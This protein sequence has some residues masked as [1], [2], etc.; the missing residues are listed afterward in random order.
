MEEEINFPR[1]GTNRSRASTET[2]DKSAKTSTSSDE[3]KQS[4]K[5]SNSGDFLFGKDEIMSNKK[6][7]RKKKRTSD[8][9]SS[10]AFSSS[11]KL[12]IGGA[13]V[14]QPSSS[15]GIKKPALI[16]A[17]SF[18]KLAKGTKILGLVREV[19]PAY[20]VVSLP[21]ML[22]GFI[23][24]S[25]VAMDKILSVGMMLP[26]VV[27]KVASETVAVPQANMSKNGKKKTEVKR[28]IELSI[29]PAMLN[30]GL[31]RDMIYDGMTIRGRIQS[32]E[33]HGCIVDLGINGLKSTS[34]F[35]KFENIEGSYDVVDVSEEEDDSDEEEEDEK[36]DT[37]KES[38]M[39]LL[40][41]GRIYDFTI[42]SVPSKVENGG[43]SSLV[44]SIIQLKLETPSTRSKNI[45]DNTTSKRQTIRTL[46]PGMLLNVTVEHFA[47]NGL[48]VSF[49]GHVF[50][51]SIDSS[52]LGAQVSDDMKKRGDI[53]ASKPVEQLWW[54]SVFVGDLRTVKAR[55]IVVD[56]VTKIIRLSLL[57]HILQLKIPSMNDFPPVGSIVDNAKVVRLDPGIGALLA[58]PSDEKMNE[59]TENNENISPTSSLENNKLY[60]LGS[61]IQCAYV[62]ISKAI[63]DGKNRTPESVFGKKFSPNTIIPKLRVLSTSYW[64]DNVVSCATS[65]SIVSSAVLTH[66]DLRPGD[67]YKSVPIIATLKGG[68]VF[69][70]LGAMGNIKGLVPSMH[71]F[72]RGGSESSAFRSK[73]RLEKFKVGNKIDVRC[74]FVDAEEKKCLL[75]TKK[76]LL[77]S[78]ID[79]PIRDYTQIEKGRIGTGFVTRVSKQG[80]VVTFYNNVYGRISARKLAE[81]LGVE[82][83]TVDYQIGDVVKARVVNC[84]QRSRP[85]ED[86]GSSMHYILS[87][88]LDIT[89]SDDNDMSTDSQGISGIAPGVVLPPKCMKVVEFVTSKVGDSNDVVPGYA[90]VTIKTKYLKDVIEGE[91]KDSIDCKIPFEQLKDSYEE[92]VSESPDAIDSEAKKVLKVGKKIDKESIILA[93]TRRGIYIVSLKP[94]LVDIAKASNDSASDKSD[95]LLPGPSSSLL[96]GAYLKGYCARIDHRHGAFIRFLD[97]LT[98]LVPKSKGGLDIKP[99]DTINCKVISLDTTNA[100][101]PRILLKTVSTSH[102]MYNSVAIMPNKEGPFARELIYKLINDGDVIGDVKVNALTFNQATVTILNKKFDSCKDIKA[103]IHMTLADPV[104]GKLST[105]PLSKVEDE[106]FIEATD[107][108]LTITK[109]HPFSQWKVGSIIQ[110][111]VFAGVSVRDGATYIELTNR[112]SDTLSAKENE[113]LAPLIADEARLL[114][115]GM[116]VSGII[117]ALHSKGIWVQ[118]N[119]T[120]SGFISGLDL[121]SN[122]AMLNNMNNYYK[123][124]GRIKCTVKKDKGESSGKERLRLS[125]SELS[126][127][128][129]ESSTLDETQQLPKE[130][131]VLVGRVNRKMKE[132]TAPS[133]MFDLPGGLVGRCDITELADMDE[134]SNMP[135]GRYEHKVKKSVENKKKQV[136]KTEPTTAE[137]Q[138][139][140]NDQE[141]DNEDDLRNEQ[142]LMGDYPNGLY[143]RCVVLTKP[144]S[145]KCS[146][147]INVSLRESRMKGAL[148]EG[149][150]PK[151][152]SIV[153]A[154]VIQTTKKG[155]FFR[156]SRTVE[157][158]AILKELSDGFL[159]DP[160]SLFP[161]GRLVVAKVKSVRNI[162][163]GNKKTK[164]AID[165]D[166]RESI[167]LNDNK[168]DFDDVKEGEKYRGV[169]TRIES[170]GVFVR[171]DNSNVS[172]L[173]HLS[174]CS[175]DYVKD[176]SSLYNPGDLVKVLVVRVEK[177]ER[178]IGMS[179]R[180][181]HF[182]EDDESIGESSS[183]SDDDVE[184]K[185]AG[186]D[187][188]D[189]IDSDDENFVSKLATKIQGTENENKD[190]VSSANSWDSDSS[191][192]DD[193]S[194]ESSTSSNEGN[195]VETMDTDVGFDWGGN[196][197]P[198]NEDPSK[199]NSD[200]SSSDSSDSEDDNDEKKSSHKSRKKAAAKKDKEKEIAQMEQRI[201]DGMADE[202]P[203]TEA[204]FERL[205]ASDPNSSENW[206]RYMSFYLSLANI[207]SARKVANRALERIEFRREEDKLNVFLAL[208]TL[209]H[210]YGSNETFDTTINKASQYNNPKQVYLR[211]CEML[212]KDAEKSKNAATITRTDEMFTKM[213]KKFKSKKTVWV[214]CFR[215]F[216]KNGRY[217]KAHELRKRSL[218][219][220]AP[221]KHVEVM[222]RYAQLEYEYGDTERARTIY[223]GLLDKNTKRLDLLFVYVDKE[224]KHGT[225]DIARRI[226]QRVVKPSEGQTPFKFSDKQMKSLFKKW[227]RMED[228]HG[229]EESQQNVKSAAKEYI[230]QSLSTK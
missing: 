79:D 17:V 26:V 102:M 127:G 103:R 183:D 36:M 69:V 151:E 216:L 83:P 164:T 44:N 167:L 22:T 23:R 21:T 213:C 206:I 91:Q 124:G 210:R 191:D 173:V 153:Q 132:V 8:D 207:D 219:S 88:S 215:Y 141:D 85:V 223:D 40:N 161:P 76:S 81:E 218:M 20:A 53:L 158:R 222:S 78:D 146:S 137:N 87:L 35:L 4:R 58:L 123:V 144:T 37:D 18:Q 105:M 188:D 192:D 131:D 169:V 224:V 122:V 80:I 56:P 220:L 138:M 51:G 15:K 225:I 172:G 93:T 62:H 142:S 54:K 175:D 60:A 194:D 104:V 61:T 152:K 184:M 136:S 97:N 59:D 185:D 208:I 221:H 198:A 212:E 176:L 74:L 28:R 95:I 82:D 29:A 64:M 121:G 174:E 147:I 168:L 143:V 150:P 128:S 41:K 67:I 154:Y 112:D 116:I 5:R 39:F 156:L 43:T 149:E 71:L 55:L 31:N 200:S 107:E 12:P 11:S 155:C 177:D 170:Y 45:I 46:C 52:N 166:L 1:G 77:T 33:D 189:D 178:R 162:K 140:T 199:D 110:D 72:D 113:K 66:S 179:M 180:A 57:P 68:G 24:Q 133:L 204:E 119:P 48:C 157:G 182:D 10:S 114:Q 126:S 9:Q 98:G 117:T 14:L 205:L 32:V 227:Y 86:G 228:E 230:D 186:D 75:T 38:V 202:N 73:I 187:D 135:L 214:S 100:S 139:K 27:Q 19:A 201:A 195:A 120:L 108:K 111:V 226:F 16:E 193:S 49:L 89:G 148:D 99:F 50:R 92:G 217:E 197:T 84:I 65:D 96:V 209:E 2:E 47:R 229:N 109:Y 125:V 63:D 6:K 34:S 25:N 203:E 190:E 134:W 130:G 165:L 90:T 129:Q 106:Q 30:S 13:G 115:S 196:T 3:K 211:V 181:S 94:S 7:S 163:R 171:I 70:Q 145:R 160:F 101:A 118:I 42:S 159:H